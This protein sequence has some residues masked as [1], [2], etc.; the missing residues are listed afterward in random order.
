MSKGLSS[1]L[2]FPPEEEMMEASRVRRVPS[3]LQPVAMRGGRL[4]RSKGSPQEGVVESVF[5]PGW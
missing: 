1:H 2:L 4:G 5:P 3:D